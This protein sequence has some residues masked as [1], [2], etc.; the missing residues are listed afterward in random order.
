MK[1]SDCAVLVAKLFAAF[2]AMKANR[3]T[4]AVYV[5]AL[6]GLPSSAALNDAVNELIRTE[7]FTPSVAAVREEYQRYVDRHSPRGLPEPELTEDQRRENLAKLREIA[8]GIGRE[9]QE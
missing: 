4:I 5:D 8:A 2:P 9:V 6:A 7:R 3:E 1:E